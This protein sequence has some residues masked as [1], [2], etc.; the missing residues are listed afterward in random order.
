MDTFT[1]NRQTI[2]FLG[3]L[4]LLE[5]LMVLVFPVLAIASALI[6]F[7]LMVFVWLKAGVR[8]GKWLW[9]NLGNVPLTQAEGAIAMSSALLFV[10]G[11]LVGGIEALRYASGERTLL[12][13]YA[14]RHMLEGSKPDVP[15]KPVGMR[16]TH[17]SDPDM[18][19]ALKVELAKAGIPHKLETTDGKEFVMWPKE[20]DAAVEEIQGRVREAPSRTGRSVHFDKPATQQ[21]FKEW[22]AKRGVAY[23]ATTRLGKEYVTWKDG[24]PDLAI[25]FLREQHVPCSRETA[26]AGSTG[27]TD[28]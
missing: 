19:M 12:T 28:C 27:K 17:Y 21:A 18:Q 23:E 25:E 15:T 10:C 16:G 8:T 4:A 11:V 22:L 24:S 9:W 6:A 26:A 3:I 7:I 5:L 14:F 2:A 20:H 13:G 1:F